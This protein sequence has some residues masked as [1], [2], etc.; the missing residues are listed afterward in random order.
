MFALFIKIAD[1]K[2]EA[3]STAQSDKSP[4]SNAIKKRSI[5]HS[6]K[7][8]ALVENIFNHNSLNICKNYR[9]QFL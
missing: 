8:E 2:I 9:L 7:I 4:D 3:V 5:C 6:I 1:V